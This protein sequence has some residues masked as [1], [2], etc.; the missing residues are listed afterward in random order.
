MA[1]SVGER[2]SK[3]KLGF[4]GGGSKIEML[5]SGGRGG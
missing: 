1:C 4:F 3:G 5:G 2:R